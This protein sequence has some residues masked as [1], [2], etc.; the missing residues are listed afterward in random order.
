M[1][2]LEE[3]M[4]LYPLDVHACDLFEIHCALVQIP[5]LAGLTREQ[6]KSTLKI[7]R[8]KVGPCM[9]MPTARCANHVLLSRSAGSHACRIPGCARVMLP[10]CLELNAALERF[11]ASRC[12]AVL[13]K[14][15]GWQ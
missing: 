3:M 4:S 6:V 8:A 10:S 9:Q 7:E 2:A 1:H 13:H 5:V 12:S 11:R 14:L 15:D